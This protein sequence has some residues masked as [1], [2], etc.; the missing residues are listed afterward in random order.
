MIVRR[1]KQGGLFGVLG[2]ETDLCILLRG[3]VSRIGE[4]R[5]VGLCEPP[6]ER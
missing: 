2:Y 5:G 4:V 1:I 3:Y 6:E